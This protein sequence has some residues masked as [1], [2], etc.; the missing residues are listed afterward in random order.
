MKLLVESR[1]NIIVESIQMVCECLRHT[2]K[3]VLP[4]VYPTK[5]SST[6]P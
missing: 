6:A 4:T 1:Y 2:Q 5:T 3:H